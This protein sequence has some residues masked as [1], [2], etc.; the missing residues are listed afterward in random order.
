MIQISNH[1]IIPEEQEEKRKKMTAQLSKRRGIS[2]TLFCVTLPTSGDGILEIIP[3]YA[4]RLEAK[5]HDI[6]VLG[7]CEG[8]KNALALVEKMLGD[9]YRETGAFDVKTYYQDKL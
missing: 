8:R 3:V 5:E 2:R 6:T 1:L 4:L 7:V 9:V